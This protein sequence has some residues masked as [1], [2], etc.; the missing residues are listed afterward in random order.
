MKAASLAESSYWGLGKQTREILVV[1]ALMACTCR[2]SCLYAHRMKYTSDHAPILGV[3]AASGLQIYATS[4]QEDSQSTLGI[5]DEDQWMRDRDKSLDRMN[6]RRERRR[7]GDVR[8]EES[9]WNEDDVVAP[10]GDSESGTASVS[11]S[12]ELSPKRVSRSSDPSYRTTER[13]ESESRLQRSTPTA[14]ARRTNKTPRRF[15]VSNPDHGDDY[16]PYSQG[17]EDV[18]RSGSTNA[19]SREGTYGRNDEAYMLTHDALAYSF[20]AAR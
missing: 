18:W 8:R 13:T 4:H 11:G 12:W 3:L 5:E 9:G 19:L 7:R 10:D 2:M 15:H 16:H 6:A 1:V 14:R 20:G 17:K